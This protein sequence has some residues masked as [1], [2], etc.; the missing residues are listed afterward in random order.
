MIRL[1]SP[2]LTLLV[3]GLA[4]LP[5][6]PAHAAEEGADKDRWMV[7]RLFAPQLVLQHQ[8]K[9]KLSDKQKAALGTEIKRVQAQVA[10]S[11]WI[12]L[13][14]SATL[15]E[16]IDAYP[17]DEQAVLVSTDKVFAAES[18]KKRLYL[19]MLVRIKNLLTAEQVSYLRGVDGST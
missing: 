3:L 15:Q 17:V 5:S 18:A 2:L 9:L 19:G 12:L 10:E 14:E 16:L 7:G 11:D 1:A 8:A 6:S 4:A 13:T